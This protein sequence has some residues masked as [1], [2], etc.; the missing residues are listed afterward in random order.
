M[1]LS[2]GNSMNTCQLV[3]ACLTVFE[4]KVVKTLIG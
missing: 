1:S 4:K 3:S 2:W